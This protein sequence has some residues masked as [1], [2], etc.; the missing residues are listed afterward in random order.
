MD[1][2]KLIEMLEHVAPQ[3]RVMAWDPDTEEYQEIS[4]IVWDDEGKELIVQTD[5]P[6]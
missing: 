4:G 2:R 3:T 1:A 5:D 6:A